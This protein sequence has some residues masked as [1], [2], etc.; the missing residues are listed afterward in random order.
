[1]KNIDYYLFFLEIA[2]TKQYQGNSSEIRMDRN[3]YNL[4]GDIRGAQWR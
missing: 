4:V 3:P 2:S 1:M